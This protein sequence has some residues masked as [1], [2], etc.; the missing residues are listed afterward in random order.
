MHELDDLF[1][2]AHAYRRLIWLGV[3]LPI[4]AAYKPAA[5]VMEH[6]SPQTSLPSNTFSS[7]FLLRWKRQRAGGM[8]QVVLTII[9][10]HGHIRCCECHQTGRWA[11][12]MRV[13][14][15]HLLPRAP[16]CTQFYSKEFA[17]QSSSMYN[18]DVLDPCP[19][20]G[21]Y[22]PARKIGLMRHFHSLHVQLCRRLP[23]QFFLHDICIA[24]DKF[25]HIAKQL[26][27][28]SVHTP[29][30]AQ[31]CREPTTFATLSTNCCRTEL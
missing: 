5:A 31:S 4:P 14:P 11:Y 6:Y 13:F 18:N 29:T 25:G 28:L 23:I 30:S 8:I 24:E 16:N 20:Y 26:S 15:P 1:C 3:L 7:F 22:A 12:Y 21:T 2:D 9:Q 17:S 27:F 19:L 10:K